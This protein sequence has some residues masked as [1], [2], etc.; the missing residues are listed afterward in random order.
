MLELGSE[1]LWFHRETGRY[2]VGRADRLVCVG[3]RARAIGEGAA[4]AGF[5]PGEIRV[6][7]DAEQAASLL[8]ST[9]AEGDTA[10]FKASR[11]VGLDRA[12]QLLTAG[13][14]STSG[15]GDAL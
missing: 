15:S 10:L 8:D 14:A 13:R 9:L 11:G 1:D 7:E 6:L 3:P 5:P 2:A 4:A 12:V